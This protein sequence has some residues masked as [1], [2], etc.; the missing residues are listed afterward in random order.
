MASPQAY[1]P[2]ITSNDETSL[3][4]WYRVHGDMLKA[5]QQRYRLLQ[6]EIMAINQQINIQ[7][8]LLML[9][10]PGLKY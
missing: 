6:W 2:V 3:A 7:L 10:P 9:P 1:L 8:E 5:L 4:Q